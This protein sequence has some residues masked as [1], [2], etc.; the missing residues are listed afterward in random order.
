MSVNGKSAGEIATVLSIGESTVNG[1]IAR[2]RAEYDTKDGRSRTN[3]LQIKKDCCLS[4][5]KKTLGQAYNRRQTFLRSTR[6]PIADFCLA[7]NMNNFKVR[8][9]Q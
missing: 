8:R 3:R 1:I 2:Y 7:E 4:L 6:V 5:E 9:M